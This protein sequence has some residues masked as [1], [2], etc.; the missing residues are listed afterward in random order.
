MNR[1]V[2][3]EATLAYRDSVR[4]KHRVIMIMAR[5]LL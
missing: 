2:I 3:L 1:V 5:N 4:L